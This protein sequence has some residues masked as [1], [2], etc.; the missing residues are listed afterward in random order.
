MRAALLLAE[1]E[2]PEGRRAL[3]L[4]LTG[5]I[6]AVAARLG[7]TRSVCRKCY[8]HPAVAASWTEGRLADELAAIRRRYR[9]APQ[10]VERAEHLVLRW[11]EQVEART[12]S[13]A[14][15]GRTLG[16]VHA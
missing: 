3:A 14:E 10:G 2:P 5:A 15:M 12:N 4:A 8:I 7:N 6:D 11:L 16:H 1:T 9:R 13:G